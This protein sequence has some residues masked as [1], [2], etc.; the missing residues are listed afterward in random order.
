MSAT[1]D[2]LWLGLFAVY[3]AILVFATV[4]ELFDIAWILDLVDLKKVFSV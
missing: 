3:V 4:G 2:R 1:R